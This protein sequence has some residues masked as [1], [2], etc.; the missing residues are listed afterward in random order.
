M[1]GKCD[2]V[3]SR[4]RDPLEEVGPWEPVLGGPCAAQVP[5]CILFPLF[6]SETPALP[7]QPLRHSIQ[8]YRIKQ[9]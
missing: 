2:E 7:A 5:F 9:R 1:I 4:R 3:Q 6:L 8:V